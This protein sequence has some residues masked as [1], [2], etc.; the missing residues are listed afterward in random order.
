MIN[1]GFKI[2]S[3]YSF[4]FVD[5]SQTCLSQCE[6]FAVDFAA[7]LADCDELLQRD[8]FIDKSRLFWSQNFTKALQSSKDLQL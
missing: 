2:K 1:F 8:R 4:L 5:C 6:K 7:G 3:V